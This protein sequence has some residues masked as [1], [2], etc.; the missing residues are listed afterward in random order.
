MAAWALAW[1]LRNPVVSGR[2]PP[3]G[4]GLGLVG[5]SERA[6]LRGGRLGHGT[7][8]GVFWLRVWIP[9]AT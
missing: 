6:E 9:W 7:T 5:L 4:A 2:T 3:P 1:V 8:D